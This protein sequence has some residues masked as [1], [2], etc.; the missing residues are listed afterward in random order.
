M[1]P[2][3]VVMLAVPAPVSIEIHRDAVVVGVDGAERERGGLAVAAGDGDGVRAAAVL[4][5]NRQAVDGLAGGGRG[6]ADKV[7]HTP[8]G[9]QR[10]GSGCWQS[11]LVLLV[12]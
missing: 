1:V 7:Q 10:S 2:V 12:V 11:C 4:V 3:V 9:T 6:V 8:L 5:V